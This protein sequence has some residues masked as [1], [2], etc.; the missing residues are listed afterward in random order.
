LA[1]SLGKFNGMERG[2]TVLNKGMI[3]LITDFGLKDNYVGIMKGVIYS[4]NPNIQIVDITHGV[5]KFNIRSGAF[6]LYTAYKHFPRGTIFVYVVDPGV[7]THREPIAIKTSKYIFI[8]P[9]NGFFSLIYPEDPPLEIRKIE[10]KEYLLDT[11][12]YT[13]HGRDI[14]APAAAHLSKGIPFENLG[15]VMKPEDLI[16][17]SVQKP[18]KEGNKYICTV[19]HIDD[20][21]NIITNMPGRFFLEYEQ[22][23]SVFSIAGKSVKFVKTFGEVSKG[24]P[25]LI[26][27]SFNLI[28]ISVNQGSA[29]D[30]FRINV[31]DNIMIVKMH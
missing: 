27:D 26:I 9:N 24:E 20:F 14:F 2:L 12:S 23:G 11:L 13:F 19:L 21:G 17:F 25:I 16:L 28:E 18:Q 15:E 6:L 31:G 30:L 10:N 7:G 1:K 5:P 3:A 8:G 4:I 22:F 29:K